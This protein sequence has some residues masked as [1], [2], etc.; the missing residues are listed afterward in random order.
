M[1]LYALAWGWIDQDVYPGGAF[2]WQT[3]RGDE[4]WWTTKKLRVGLG[5]PVFKA[6]LSP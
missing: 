2:V 6:S 5:D 3:N 4:Q 1:N